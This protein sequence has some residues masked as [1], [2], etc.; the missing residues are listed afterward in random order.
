MKESSP[1]LRGMILYYGLH[2]CTSVAIRQV[3]EVG[4]HLKGLV[5]APKYIHKGA[6][7]H[8]PFLGNRV[9][10]P[11]GTTTAPNTLLKC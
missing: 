10:S 8:S 5:Q 11:S 4:A 9:A 2:D 3:W 6:R 7:D 1:S